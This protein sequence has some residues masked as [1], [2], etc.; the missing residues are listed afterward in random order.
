VGSTGFLS[1]EIFELRKLS[2][3]SH[4]SDFLTV[5][6]MGHSPAIALGIALEKPNRQVFDLE[7]DGSFIMHMGTTVT[8]G[9]KQPK[10]L[11]QIIIN[12][13]VHDSV[14]AQPSGAFRID[15]K[16]I[17]LAC[18]YRT[19]LYAENAH[20]I[21]ESIIKLRKAEGPALLEI[22]VHPG[23]RADLGRPTQTCQSAK[24]EFMSFINSKN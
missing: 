19:V 24:E 8:I 7:G 23:A 14:G 16:G 12:N 11:K 22:R 4:A 3:Q 9:T 21:N 2:E 17:A 10:N 13:G 15:I 6:S 1:R 18:G 5:G 20:Q